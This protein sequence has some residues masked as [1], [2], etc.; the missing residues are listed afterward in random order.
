MLCASP[1]F[2]F[3]GGIFVNRSNGMTPRDVHLQRIKTARSD[4]LIVAIL[5]VVNIVLYLAHSNTMMLFSA[6]VPYYAVVFAD[7]LMIPTVTLACYAVALISIVAYFV[8][9][10]LS[11]KRHIFLVFAT[12]LFSLDFL[13]LLGL[14]IYAGETGG[15]MDMVI[16][17]VVLYF[18]ILGSASV[19]PLKNLP[20]EVPTATE[21]L[22]NSVPLRRAEDEGKVRILLEEQYSTYHIVY[23]RVKR[24]NQLVINNYI[25][26]E[27]S[28]LVEPPHNL[29]AVIDGHL[30]EVGFDGTRSYIHVDGAVL[31]TKVRI[32]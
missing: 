10:L 13:V 5:T 2:L 20:E 7:L 3:Q 8:F 18:L 15:F 23:R 1:H 14:H 25:Y 21:E 6:A 28:Y 22:T 19:R 30:I 27:V 24:L 9:W 12:V 31:Q 16:H 4:L 26:D 32:F 29:T 17:A 11:K